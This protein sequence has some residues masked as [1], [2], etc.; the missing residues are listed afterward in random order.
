MKKNGLVRL[1][2]LLPCVATLAGCGKDD[3][4]IY[5]KD[6]PETFHLGETIDLDKYVTV[7]GTSKS[8]KVYVYKASEELVS[9]KDHKITLKEEGEITF[10]IYIGKVEQVV[11]VQSIA[12]M[13]EALIKAF[14]EYDGEYLAYGM[15]TGD[16]F[17]HRE[18]YGV[19]TRFDYKNLCD[20][21]NGYVSA[22]SADAGYEFYSDAEGY[23]YGSPKIVSKSSFESLNHF[24]ADIKGAKRDSIKLSSGDTEVYTLT[25]SAM[26]NFTSSVMLTDASK[27]T[28]SVQT[29]TVGEEDPTPVYEDVT[30]S[31]SRV[32][33]TYLDVS[34]VKYPSALVYG[35]LN[36][37]TQLIDALVFTN[38]PSNF[39]DDAYGEYFANHPNH[40][41]FK[42]SPVDSLF[43]IFTTGI[44]TSRQLVAEFNYGWFDKEGERIAEPDDVPGTYFEGLPVGSVTRVF[45]ENAIVD[46]VD[47]KIVSGSVQHTESLVTTVYDVKLVSEIVEGN[48]VTHHKPTENPD[49]EEVYENPYASLAHIVDEKNMPFD[50]FFVS[51]TENIGT[52]QDPVTKYTLSPNLTRHYDF[53]DGIFTCEDGLAPLASFFFKY[54]DKQLQEYF[55]F[56][57]TIVPSQLAM[58]MEA[59]LMWD[60]QGNQNY[61][62]VLDLHED[63]TQE[64]APLISALFTEL[65]GS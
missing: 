28:L 30:T 5:V 8:F 58:H 60:R 34:G 46:V 13:R 29:G 18:E 36:N 22:A 16:T 37:K 52:E 4:K 45:S 32:D 38:D 9:V 57:L 51:K 26:K 19:R 56:S 63:S 44:S 7:K 12:E 10:S 3:P 6:L 54:K 55:S 41:I 27:Y 40:L 48:E 62:I 23:Y 17:N 47:E 50:S 42:D 11:T 15:N 49:Y 1:L 25:S 31:I 61:K 59:S 20:I 64:Y 33:F 2:A 21:K 65:F 43:S 39:E 14:A 53:L 35:K 24:N